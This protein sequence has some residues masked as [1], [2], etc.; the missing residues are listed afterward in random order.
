MQDDASIYANHAQNNDPRMTI[1][2]SLPGWPPR[3]IRS[4]AIC[5]ANLCYHFPPAIL[6]RLNFVFS[7]CQSF[8]TLRTLWTLILGEDTMKE[9]PSSLIPS[10]LREFVLSHRL[11]YD[12]PSHVLT[13]IKDHWVHHWPSGQWPLPQPPCRSLLTVVG[14]RNLGQ[15]RNIVPSPRLNR[16]GL[17]TLCTGHL[18]SRMMDCADMGGTEW[19]QQCATLCNMVPLKLGDP[20]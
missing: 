8:W 1:L 6:I 19:V 18:D 16:Q 4:T 3:M 17:A 13:V 7:C 2:G 15:A 20:T 10:Q 12:I 14:V 5:F 9:P 11:S